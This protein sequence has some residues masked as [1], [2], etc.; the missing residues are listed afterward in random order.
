MKIGF[1]VVLGGDLVRSTEHLGVSYIMSYLRKYGYEV[2]IV[3]VLGVNDKENIGKLLNAKYDLVGFTT[4]CVN[5]DGI[6]KVAQMVKQSNNDC[7]VWLGGHMATFWGEKILKQYSY[8]DFIIRGEGEITT[9]ELIKTI[10]N[11]ENLSKVDGLTYRENDKI[12]VNKDR[13]LIKNLDELPFPAR[14]QFDAHDNNFQYI[15]I[16]SSR[17]CLGKCGFCSSFVG[18]TQSDFKWRG[19]S[20]KNVVDEIE[21]LT[22][23]YDFHTIDFID[24]TYEDPGKLGK[25]RIKEIAEEILKRDLEVYYNCCF[26]AEN[27]SDDDRELLDILI[28]SGL[29]KV[30]IGFESGNDRGLKI[31]NKRATMEDNRRVI[32][33]L[34]D[35]PD[36][37]ITFGFIMFHP[38]STMNDLKDNGQFLYDTGIGQVIRHYFWQLEVYPSTLME[39]MLIRDNMIKEQYD[40]CHGMYKY[41]FLD[42]EV[43]KFA[44]LCQE[45]LKLESVWD[46]EIF[47]ILIHTFITR[48]KRKYKN[49]EKIYS[50][51]LEFEDF[52]N[53]IRREMASFN[54]EFFTNILENNLNFDIEEQKNRLDKFILSKMEKVKDGQLKLGMSLQREGYKLIKR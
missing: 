50:K 35:F 18:R 40:I 13:E 22:K 6:L 14:D 52:V 26:R 48:L 41:N 43:E 28:K 21:Y 37:Y 9:L 30:N 16:C 49:E 27:W 53:G 10:E 20:P 46:Y 45:F 12:V 11:K 4:T 39:D 51:I 23:K 38:Y 8:V 47:D 19:R 5:M 1:V 29:E 36:I 32:K 2:D 3:E 31:L 24:S 17:G 34:A 15:R 25:S 33:L 44:G 42:K 7:H 54:I